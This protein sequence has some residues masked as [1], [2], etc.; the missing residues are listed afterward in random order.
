M[1]KSVYTFIRIKKS[2]SFLED[3]DDFG[4]CADAEIYLCI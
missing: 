2:Q 4:K 1:K 3:D